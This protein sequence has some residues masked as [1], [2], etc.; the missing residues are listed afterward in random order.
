VSR[1]AP[2]VET[3]TT[4]D[5]ARR[6]ADWQDL[7]TRAA[8]PNVFA[9]SA[10][11]LSALRLAGAGLTVLLVWRDAS[12]RGLIGVAAL[13]APPLGQGLARIWRSEQAGLAAVMFDAELVVEALAA[14]LAWLRARPGVAGL[15]LPG[16]ERDGALA[17]AV[18]ALS[19]R[20]AL[21]LEEANP[22]RRAA[23]VLGCAA[24]F[25][26]GLEKKR[27]KEWARQGRRLAERGRLQ[28]RLVEGAEGIE[29]FLALEAKGWKGARGTALGADRGRRAFA[30][31][32]L[33]AFTE[34]DRLQIHELVLADSAIAMGV[35]LRAGA[36][37]FYW[38]T[39][40]DEG[41]GEFSPG[42]Q[43]T[44]ALSRGLEREPGLALVDSCA[45]QDHPMIDRIWLGRIELVDFVFAAGE[46]RAWRLGA[47][48]AVERAG[49]ALRERVKRIVN[50]LRGRKH[51]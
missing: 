29:R 9:E 46:E 45:L 5:L 6:E 1:G 40:Y 44:L 18:R 20:A 49:S 51:S 42:V 32:M 27:R 21:R 8:E 26:A 43:L 15:I 23:L 12:R 25:E 22:R 36:R 10:F 30:R 31:A 7:A 14:V 33:G 24:G 13:R 16:V 3:A 34:R 39:A 50:R 47:W 2:F 19:V 48:L 35:V 41:V 17:R 11:L 4:D 38:K 37:A 28:A